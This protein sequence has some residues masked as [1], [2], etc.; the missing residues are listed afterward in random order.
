MSKIDYHIQCMLQKNN[1]STV[2][3]IEEKY[4]ILNKEVAM[5]KDNDVW[6]EGWIVTGVGA[7]MESKYVKNQAH[8][9][10]NIWTATSGPCPRGNK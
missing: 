1:I 4:A 5:E 7:K 8:N 9:S 6:E 10:N 2:A 3:W